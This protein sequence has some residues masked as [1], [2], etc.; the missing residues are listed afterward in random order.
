MEPLLRSCSNFPVFPHSM[1]NLRLLIYLAF[2]LLK[3]VLFL[4]LIADT[5]HIFPSMIMN[6]HVMINAFFATDIFAVKV[7]LNVM[8]GFDL[9]DPNE[10]RA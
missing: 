5:F 4:S 10:S 8:H 6:V 3:F 2:F 1:I 7:G 9:M